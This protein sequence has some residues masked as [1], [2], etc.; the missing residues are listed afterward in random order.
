MYMEY[1]RGKQILRILEK[2]SLCLEKE[3]PYV[4]KNGHFWANFRECFVYLPLP[5]NL[6]PS[7]AH[8]IFLTNG[9]LVYKIH[10]QICS[11]INC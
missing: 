8:F 1:T 11:R 2:E 10:N 4:R 5:Q 7:H 9:L 3:K 6:S